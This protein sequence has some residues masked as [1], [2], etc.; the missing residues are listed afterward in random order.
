MIG[1]LSSFNLGLEISY[2]FTV[3]LE[4]SLYSDL[5]T[6]TSI[7]E[8][9]KTSCQFSLILESQSLPNR[10]GRCPSEINSGSLSNSLS[11][12]FTGTQHSPRS[13]MLSPIYERSKVSVFVSWKSYNWFISTDSQ[14]MVRTLPVS[15]KKST[16][17]R[18]TVIFTEN[19][20]LLLSVSLV[21]KM[22]Q[23]L[24]SESDV[25]PSPLSTR[26]AGLS[27]FFVVGLP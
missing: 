14:M 17:S 15:T 25:L 4:K 18:P 23:I 20:L 9:P 7:A 26:K 3:W 11:W 27:G 12:Y 6:S 21:Q 2:W 13:P 10:L 5:R 16:F 22:E 24:S 19:I 1:C 8:I